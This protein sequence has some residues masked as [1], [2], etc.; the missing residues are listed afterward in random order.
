MSVGTEFIIVI[1]KAPLTRYLSKLDILHLSLTNKGIRIKLYPLIFNDLIIEIRALRKH[2]SYFNQKKYHQFNNLTY[3]EKLRLVRK[4]GFNKD[5]AY[6]ELYIDSFI[7]ELNNNL[8]PASNHCKSLTLYNLDRSCWCQ[9]PCHNFINLLTKLKSLDILIMECTNLILNKS[10]DPNLARNLKFPILLK[11]LTY[12]SVRLGITD[13]YQLK[14]KQ[15]I[16]SIKLD[17]YI[18]DLEIAPQALPNLTYFKFY[19]NGRG[20]RKLEEFMALNPNVEY[21]DDF[22]VSEY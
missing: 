1:V 11:E 7:E 3:I 10:E 14:P 15:I 19:D 8:S 12:L 20:A 17:Y 18:E 2:P 4:Y 6:K 22:L 9:V 21:I 13:C 5:L 16:H